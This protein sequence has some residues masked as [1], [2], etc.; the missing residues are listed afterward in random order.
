MIEKNPL[1]ER[2]ASG[3]P[4]LGTWNTLAAPLVTEALAHA[5]L[6]FVIVD[7]EHGPFQ[8]DKVHEYV[9]C[10]ERHGTSPLVRIPSA[11]DWMA[12][13]ALD[14]GAHGIMVPH[15]DDAR[16]A[17]SIVRSARYYPK[18]TRG[19]TPFTKAGG[20][21]PEKA[22]AY[23]DRANNLVLTAALIESRESLEN[24]DSILAVDGLDIVYFGAYDLSQA[25]GVPGRVDDP[26]VLKAVEDGVKKAA[27]AGKA[28]G[29]FVAR[30]QED[31]RRL[32][33]MGM[34]FITYDVDTSILSRP[35]QA[36][37]DWF[38]GL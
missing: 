36:I 7:F 27:D 1:K 18:G 26:K 6:D 29:G 31:V 14:Q 21:S 35:V 3:K 15:V 28:A 17:E 10:C 2:L 20:F 16:T 34:T 9:N 12:L 24:L 30:S 4:A 32:L 25:V 19:Y 37:T 8:I 23:T 13:Q 22:G 11:A 5:G 33:G 38:K